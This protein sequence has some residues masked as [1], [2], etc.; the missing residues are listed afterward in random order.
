M[1]PIQFA[2]E[3]G[4]VPLPRLSYQSTFRRESPVMRQ[5]ELRDTKIGGAPYRPK[6]AG[7]PCAQNGRPYTFVAQLN[8]AQV[9]RDRQTLGVPP[10]LDGALPT[11][12]LIQFFLPFDDVYGCG[13]GEPECFVAFIP[14]PTLPAEDPVFA[15]IA[16]F[17]APVQWIHENPT[18]EINERFGRLAPSPY[19][20]ELSILEHPE[21]AQALE[22]IAL[23][24]MMQYPQPTLHAEVTD[25]QEAKWR[26]FDP[27]YTF[28]K[29]IF[30]KADHQVGGYSDLVQNELR[31]KG[32]PLR[33]LFH[34]NSDFDMQCIG[35]MGTMQFYIDP[36]DLRRRDFSKVWMDWACG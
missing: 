24:P 7:W 22:P 12:G 29:E 26:E 21:V 36:A 30:G 6:G 5:A 13:N 1:E 8:L 17:D 32:T 3:I 11:T 35:D 16:D 25:E 28:V 31:P 14:D 4:L 27:D 10:L 15:W 9:E 33:L 34:I 18:P 19:S 23:E 2:Q 20:T